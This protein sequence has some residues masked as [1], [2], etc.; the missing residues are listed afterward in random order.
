MV[1]AILSDRLVGKYHTILWLSMVYTAGHAVLSLSDLGLIPFVHSRM[2]GT[3][4]GL[5]LIAIGAGGIKP[6]VSAHVGDQFGKG[7]WSKLQSVF[8]IFYFSINLGSTFASLA[9]PWVKDIWGFSVAFAI[10][11]I[12][13]AVATFFFWM[14]RHV[15][16]H[17]P[18]SPGG[19]LGLLDAVAST[20]L[21]MTVG[22]LF[23]TNDMSVFTILTVSA[24]CLAAG[25]ALFA[26][27]QNIEPDDGFLAIV[28]YTLRTLI[29]RRE[30]DPLPQAEAEA[31]K[32]S[33]VGADAAKP[34]SEHW[35]FGPAVRRF[36]HEAAE[37][38]V[39]VLKIFSIF[40]LVSI[41]WSLFDQHSSSWI[42]QAKSMHLPT[43]LGF[44]ME[45]EMMP[46][47]NPVMVMLLIPAT[48]FGL[49]PLLDKIGLKTTPLR[50]MSFGMVLTG[51]S[52]VAAALIQQRIQAVGEGEVSVFWQLISY[53][54]LT[55]SEVMV[56]ITGL[57]FAYSQAPRKMK[58]TIMGFWLLTVAAGNVLTALIFSHFEKQVEAGNMKLDSF[59]WIFAVMMFAAGVLF[60]VRAMFYK[61]KDYTQ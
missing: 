45:P 19:K 36:G 38:P 35:F 12:L 8:Q 27:R 1:G 57:E 59:F 37:G 30:A 15:F 43:V 22:S 51:T 9:I 5:G 6:C 13:M 11:G 48:Q 55:L 18:A 7:N 10:P 20:V 46:A 39:A 47:A 31:Q 26:I 23:V 56:S 29:T 41:F 25:L 60:A 4:L 49:Y 33:V 3:Y 54:L 42:Q 58:S 21:F 50:R 40:F 28:L 16:I 14:G 17:V 24:S 61:Y 2:G 53:L 34:L 44:E 32:A 52:F